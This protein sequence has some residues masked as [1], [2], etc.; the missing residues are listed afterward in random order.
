MRVL[1]LT[2]IQEELAPLLAAHPFQ[3][4]KQYGAYRSVRYADLFAA[5]TGPGVKKIGRFAACC[6]NSRR[7]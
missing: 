6:K 3:F 1:V 4:D 5:T 7:T 2:G